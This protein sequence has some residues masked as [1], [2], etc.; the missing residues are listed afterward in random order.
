MAKPTKERPNI[1]QITRE[2]TPQLIPLY[3]QLYSHPD[4]TIEDGLMLE[5]SQYIDCAPFLGDE[6]GAY[7][8]EMLDASMEPRYRKGD[9][10]LVNPNW[11]PV[12]EEDAII[13]C[14]HN[15]KVGKSRWIAL[16]REIVLIDDVSKDEY[17]K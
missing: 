14:K 6:E 15:P 3:N 7:A 16:V 8:V 13:P 1:V 12:R 2:S 4:F 5:Q 10:L 17:S 9:I 11:M